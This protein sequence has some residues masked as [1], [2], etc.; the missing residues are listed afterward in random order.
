[1]YN[2]H[3][4]ARHTQAGR[5]A[6]A[7]YVHTRAPCPRMHPCAVV[8]TRAPRPRMHPCAHTRP[9]PTHAPMCT[10]APHAH[11]CSHEFTSHPLLLLLPLLACQPQQ[12][13]GRQHS[14]HPLLLLL[15][16]PLACQPQQVCGRQHSPHPLL[17][18]LPPLACQPQPVCGRQHS[19][20]PLLLLLPPLAC[21]PQQVSG[22]EVL[23]AAVL[24]EVPCVELFLN[25]LCAQDLGARG[26]V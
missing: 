6:R 2:T 12:V 7:P 26:G 21:Q 22:K 11:A 23:V 14:P 20:H 19:P 10:H 16:P 25:P 13:S 5:Q 1:M 15:L 8:H 3:A 4:H 17:L 18:L 9:A 24:A